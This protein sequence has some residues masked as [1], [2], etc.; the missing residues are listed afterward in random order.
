MIFTEPGP[1]TLRRNRAVQ[2]AISPL[3]SMTIYDRGD[4]SSSS[5]FMTKPTVFDEPGG[6][7]TSTGASP[8]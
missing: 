7:N 4:T 2:A 1:P 5:W 8:V 6:P 3:G